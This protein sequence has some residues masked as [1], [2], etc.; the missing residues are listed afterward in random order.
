[1]LQLDMRRVC[2]G[3]RQQRYILLLRLH[4]VRAMRSSA[5]LTTL[6]KTKE[7]NANHHAHESQQE[8]ERVVWR[9]V[10]ECPAAPDTAGDDDGLANRDD[11]GRVVVPVVIFGDGS[12]ETLVHLHKLQ[13][14]GTGGK[15]TVEHEVRVQNK[16]CI[17]P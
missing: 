13:A 17:M 7:D 10:E 5:T 1:M 2:Q 4:D 3:V 15:Y 8:Y 12:L 6:G 14:R 9:F 16:V 11:E